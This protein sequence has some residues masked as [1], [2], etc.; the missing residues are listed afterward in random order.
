MGTN[1]FLNGEGDVDLTELINE[2]NA[3]S[4]EVEGKLDKDGSDG[5]MTGNLAMNSNNITGIQNLFSFGIN[6]DFLDVSSQLASQTL[7]APT[8]NNLRI[9]SDDMQLTPDNIPGNEFMTLSVAG[10]IEANTNLDM[11][12][13]AI[14]N[15]S[16]LVS[17][18]NAITLDQEVGSAGGV[19]NSQNLTRVGNAFMGTVEI[20]TAATFTTCGFTIGVPRSA[21]FVSAA[22]ACGTVTVQD[23]NAP[24]A[25]ESKAGGGLNAVVG[26]KQIR[27]E[28]NI[29]YQNLGARII[30]VSFFYLA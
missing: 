14:E 3:L 6:T 20:A 12:G 4:N 21:N 10:G 19:I 27:M 26:A 15:C 9:V 22:L 11:G 23:G 5:G 8:L 30:S 2:I 7:V 13:N 28:T 24:G 25:Y 16:N 29:N 18:Q 1:K 17:V